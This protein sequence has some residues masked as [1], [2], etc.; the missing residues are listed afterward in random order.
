[1]A[2]GS[3]VSPHPQAGSSQVDHPGIVIVSYN[4][5]VTALHNSIAELAAI[6]YQLAGVTGRRA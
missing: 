6:S 2:S 4:S 5:A 1:M 3:H